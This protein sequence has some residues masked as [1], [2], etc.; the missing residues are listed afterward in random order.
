MIPGK[1]VDLVAVS[2]KYLDAYRKWINDPEATDMLGNVRFP[3]SRVREKKCVDGQTAG[4]SKSRNFT[5]LT[6]KGL[7]IGNVG[8]N[9]LNWQNRS[10]VLGIMIGEKDYWN[11]GYGSE[12]I[13]MVL[14]FGFQTLGLHRILLYVDS[15]NDRAVACYKKCGFVIEGTKR[16]HEFYRGED[17]ED[18]VMGILK[19][20]WEKRRG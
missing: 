3:M 6:K 18:L 13:G 19:E 2:P 15:K 16:K 5:I 12:A 10:G 8:F 14:E 20:E 17:V 4:T 11:K 1:R 9:V 7:P